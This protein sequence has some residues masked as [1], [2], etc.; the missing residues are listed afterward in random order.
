MVVMIMPSVQIVFELYFKG[1][2]NYCKC[3]EGFFSCLKD[4]FSKDSDGRKEDPTPEDFSV[5]D[6]G[7]TDIE[8]TTTITPHADYKNEG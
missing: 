7:K 8:K 3:F 6:D 4:R 1:R 2:Y 5:F